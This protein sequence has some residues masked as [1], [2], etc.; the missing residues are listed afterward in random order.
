MCVCV[1]DVYKTCIEL[2]FVM[3]ESLHNNTRSTELKMLTEY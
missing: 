3:E 2:N 1:S